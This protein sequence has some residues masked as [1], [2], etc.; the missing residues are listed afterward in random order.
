MKRIAASVLVLALF[1]CTKS[2]DTDIGV[3]E[4]VTGTRVVV[5]TPRQQSIDYVLTAL[6]TV[7]SIHHPTISAETSGQ[8]IDIEVNEGD[9][10]EVRQ[11]LATIDNTLHRIESEKASAELQRQEVLLDN[12]RR[13]VNRLLHLAKSQSVSKD[14]L[15]DE[16]AQLQMLTALRD[17][18]KKQKQQALYLD[19]KTR[20]QAP[21][22]G[23]IARRHVSLGDYVTPGQPLFS[24]V[25]IKRLR[26]RL[27]FPEHHAAGISVGKQVRLQTPAAQASVAGGMVASVNPQINPRSRAIEV[28]VEFDNPGD[29]YPGASVDA[30]LTVGQSQNALTV[31]SLSVVRRGGNDVIFVV[32]GDV[33]S[34][35]T[36]TLGWREDDWVEI[37]EGVIAEDQVVTE[38][39]ALITDGSPL[40]ISGEKAVP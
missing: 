1:G 13:E 40:V 23:L 31:P 28:I 11:L 7:E 33:A 30:T 12:Q 24:L 5:T 39:S 17:I 36:V 20:V 25:S 14:R 34:Q 32:D 26:A 29:W 22:D 27:A 21:Q 4:T 9:T 38:G 3:T 10:V 18:A 16:Q 15:E 19:S 8:I 35:R 2:V 6:G 37:T